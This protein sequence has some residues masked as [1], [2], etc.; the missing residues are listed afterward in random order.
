M[1]KLVVVRGPPAAIEEDERRARWGHDV[2]D[3]PGVLERC[4]DQGLVGGVV[5]LVAAGDDGRA[6]VFQSRSVRFVRRFMNARP[7][8]VA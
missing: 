8:G 2:A 7:C 5:D 4:L 6:T 3:E 1:E